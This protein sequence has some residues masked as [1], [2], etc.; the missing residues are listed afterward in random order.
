MTFSLAHTNPTEISLTPPGGT[1]VEKGRH[2]NEKTTTPA[3]GEH[4]E[5][6]ARGLTGLLADTY[7]LYN[8]TQFYHWNVEGPHFS[9][10]HEMFEK[11][12]L[13]LAE[14][15]DVLAERVRVLGFYAPGTL[16]ELSKLSRLSQKANVRDPKTMLVHLI[17]GHRAV[18]HRLRELQELAEKSA[19]E[20][21]MDLLVERQRR[22]EK[23]TWMLRSQAG[24]T[25]GKIALGPQ[26]RASA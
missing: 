7:V 9:E 19:D 23:L 11:Q 2:L 16:A 6:L 10:L 26:L 4:Q 20:A 24:E 22:H 1:L 17:E 12:Y 5:A 15:I 21:T 8:T 18:T 25:S 3:T 13:E 14:A